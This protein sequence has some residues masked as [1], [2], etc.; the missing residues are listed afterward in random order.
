[1]SGFSRTGPVRLKG[2]RATTRS[3]LSPPASSPWAAATTRNFSAAVHFF[4]SL[5]LSSGVIA[6]NVR[7]L[8]NQRDGVREKTI[9]RVEQAIAKLGYRANA[10]AMRLARNETYRFA[11]ILPS[12]ANSFMSNLSVQV[13]R[14]SL[15]V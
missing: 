5:R 2:G 12:N 7:A 1:M 11:F 9:A 10:A 6:A 15:R 13:E 8:V 3:G 4:G 14:S